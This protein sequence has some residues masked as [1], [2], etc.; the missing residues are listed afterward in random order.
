MLLVGWATKSS[1]KTSRAPCAQHFA[2]WE[3]HKGKKV[4]TSSVA[5]T[6]SVSPAA[7]LQESIIELLKK[8]NDRKGPSSSELR[9]TSAKPAVILVV[10]VNGSGK[11]CRMLSWS[12]VAC[13]CFWSLHLNTFLV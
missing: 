1:R 13:K 3:L 12:A 5:C 7:L 6:I 4:G 11:V 2:I 9:L 8:G 10:G